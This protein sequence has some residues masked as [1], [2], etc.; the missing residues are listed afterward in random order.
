MKAQ[1]IRA[2]LEKVQETITKKQGTLEKYRKK[3]EKIRSQILEK[4]WDLEAGRYQK[5]DTP[6]HNDCYWTFCDLDDAEEG[7]KRT[8]KAIQEKLEMLKK[9]KEQLLEALEKEAERER[10]PEIFDQYRDVVVADWD[11]WDARRKERLR[12][13]YDA[14]LA[15][16]DLPSVRWK[17]KSAFMQ[18]NGAHSI[19]F[20]RSSAEETHK[21]NVQSAERLLTNLWTRVKEIVGTATDWSGLVI[22]MGNEYEGAVINGWVNGTDGKAVVETISAG[23][24]N[25][26]KF[27]YRTLVHRW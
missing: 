11:A 9:Y 5:Q 22:R 3:A 25:I 7:I 21:E 10:F 19:E 4:G 17:K 14:L 13:E 1:D 18:K 12:K 15:D 20:M 26:Q 6:E 23:G 8:E 27:H 16:D 24:W 2:R